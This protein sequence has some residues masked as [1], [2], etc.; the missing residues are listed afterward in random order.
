MV[1]I[2]DDKA[3]FVCER[4]LRLL[5]RNSVLSEIRLVLPFIPLESQHTHYSVHGLYVQTTQALA[6]GPDLSRSGVAASSVLAPLALALKAEVRSGELQCL[7]VGARRCCFRRVGS[8]PPPRCAT[9][10]YRC[11]VWL[12]R[13]AVFAAHAFGRRRSC[14]MRSCA[15]R[16]GGVPLLATSADS[17]TLRAFGVVSLRPA[18]VGSL[19]R[20]NC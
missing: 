18:V 8:E 17:P 19:A 15:T 9:A 2:V 1:R 10:N 4:S 11:V 13:P 16:R 6:L 5:E 12:C 20:N 7:G 3:V 14:R